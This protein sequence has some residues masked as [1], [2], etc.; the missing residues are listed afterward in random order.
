MNQEQVQKEVVRRQRAI[1]RKIVTRR[2]KLAATDDRLRTAA[3]CAE[4]AVL[5]DDLTSAAP[6]TYREWLQRSAAA[7]AAAD[8]EAA[9]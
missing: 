9:A 5:L 6:D 1:M 4:I 3:L 2:Q 8:A 7:R